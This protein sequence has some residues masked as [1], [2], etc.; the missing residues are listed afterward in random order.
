MH[1]NV[2]HN[3]SSGSQQIY[4]L[5]NFVLVLLLRFI[6]NPYHLTQNFF[7]KHLV[8][9]YKILYGHSFTNKLKSYPKQVQRNF[10]LTFETIISNYS[11]KVYFFVYLQLYKEIYD[12]KKDHKVKKI[13]FDIQNL[14]NFKIETLSIIINVVNN[15]SCCS[16][17][18]TTIGGL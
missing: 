16:C 17:C 3:L 11:F 13:H 1:R 8:I 9:C 7:S 2:F 10:I 14:N 6:M 15:P 5:R 12:L 4:L 18:S